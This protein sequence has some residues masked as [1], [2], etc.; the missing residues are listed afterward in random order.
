MGLGPEALSRAPRQAEALALIKRLGRV[1]RAQIG[2]FGISRGA[3]KALVLR[4][5]AEEIELEV[6]TGPAPRQL[7]VALQRRQK[8]RR[9]IA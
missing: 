4:G 9:S 3:L 8:W 6:G 1:G 5:L 2:E 7:S